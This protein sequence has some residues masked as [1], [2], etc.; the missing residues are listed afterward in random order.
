MGG[1]SK[2]TLT[3]PDHYLWV[4]AREPELDPAVYNDL[5]TR[6]AAWDFPLTELIAVPQ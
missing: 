5:V 2:R 1:Q 4:L 6:A 3:P